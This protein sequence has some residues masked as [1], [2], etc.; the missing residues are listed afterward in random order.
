MAVNINQSSNPHVLA[1]IME[2]NNC[3]VY[4]ST[5]QTDER[6]FVQVTR[7]MSWRKIFKK[8]S[9]KSLKQYD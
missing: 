5:D 4:R 3:K 2:I 8:Y 1:L 6:M 7:C 9:N